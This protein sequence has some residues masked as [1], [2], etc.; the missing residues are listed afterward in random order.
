LG[1]SKGKGPEAK[2]RQ[3]EQFAEHDGW[4]RG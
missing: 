3:S 1:S 2:Q 4:T